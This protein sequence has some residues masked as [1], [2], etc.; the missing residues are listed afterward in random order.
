[1]PVRCACAATA[2]RLTVPFNRRAAIS[3]RSCSPCNAPCVISFGDETRRDRYAVWQRLAASSCLA[4]FP[5]SDPC[6]PRASARVRGRPRPSSRRA[7]SLQRISARSR[8]RRPGAAARR[9]LLLRVWFLLVWSP[10]ITGYLRQ[11]N[12]LPGRRQLAVVG[13]DQDRRVLDVPARAARD[14]PAS[15]PG[16]RSSSTSS[17]WRA[18]LLSSS[19]CAAA[20]GR[21]G[22]GSRPRRSSPSAAMSCSSST[23]R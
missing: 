5:Q 1:M 21:A 14:R 3:M 11:R 23:R 22:W 19:P 20:G 18:A 9:G 2:N 15:D 4:G 10:A 8:A 6:A 17:G 12:L 13:P 7:R 16:D